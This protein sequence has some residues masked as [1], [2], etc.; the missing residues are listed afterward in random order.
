MLL[1]AG[2][3]VSL[4]ITF[5]LGNLGFQY[6]GADSTSTVRMVMKGSR[7]LGQREE[8]GGMGLRT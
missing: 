1:E 7:Y 5:E 6:G 3:P 2:S 4:C 8:T